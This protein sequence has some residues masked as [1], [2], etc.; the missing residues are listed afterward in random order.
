MDKAHVEQEGWWNR[1]KAERVQA[2]IHAITDRH[3]ATPFPAMSTH[4]VQ[5]ELPFEPSLV[6]V[7][8]PEGS[9]GFT[10]KTTT[11]PLE[12]FTDFHGTSSTAQHSPNF[13]L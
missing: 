13:Y 5:P 1:R 8:Q 6:V 2:V 7:A 11:K 9:F 12:A 3:R 10:E 4:N